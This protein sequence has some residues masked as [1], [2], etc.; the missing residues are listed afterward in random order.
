MK[1]RHCD[2]CQETFVSSQLLIEHLRTMYGE[3]RAPR[4]K[5]R[6]A[7]QTPGQ[8]PRAKDPVLGSHTTVPNAMLQTSGHWALGQEAQ[9]L[10][11]EGP[12]PS[13]G[14]GE[15]EI[16]NRPSPGPQTTV[17][18]VV[19]QTSGPCP[20]GKGAQDPE[21]MEI[22]QPHSQGPTPM[23]TS[24][25]HSQQ[26]PTPGVQTTVSTEVPQTSG[27]FPQGRKPKAQNP[28]SPASHPVRKERWK[29][30]IHRG[31]PSQ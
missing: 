7:S 2:R 27:P 17:P 31:T 23:E 22:S 1:A 21:P 24:Q 18:I 9:D 12:T 5:V 30:T 15:M 16:D 8:D 10:G 19:P 26:G 14:D 13:Q 6:T 29:W 4:L 28:W 3:H 20:L 11:P 25:P